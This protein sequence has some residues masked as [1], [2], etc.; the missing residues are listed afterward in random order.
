MPEPGCPRRRGA[1]RRVCRTAAIS[2]AERERRKLVR[3]LEAAAFGGLRRI[4]HQV[5]HRRVEI[6]QALRLGVDD[7][8][9]ERVAQTPLD[10][11]D[12]GRGGLAAQLARECFGGA[13]DAVDIIAGVVK[14][15]AHLF[16]R[17]AAAFGGAAGQRLVDDLEPLAGAAIGGMERDELVGELGLLQGGAL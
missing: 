9:A 14:P 2:R 12:R 4:D 1:Q 10:R 11:L 15:V 6:A 13:I 5:A 3:Q 7:R 8:Y 16:P 17:Q